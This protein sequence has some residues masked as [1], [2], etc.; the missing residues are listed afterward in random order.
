LPYTR[1]PEFRT[2]KPGTVLYRYM[3]LGKLLHVLQCGCLWFTAMTL[4][5]EHEGRL[6]AADTDE[7][8]F[9]ARYGPDVK[10]LLYVNCWTEG[11]H[12]SHA[13]WALYTG[14]ID[15]VAIRTTVGRFKKALAPAKGEVYLGRVEYVDHD[16][17]TEPILERN[18][19]APWTRKRS[20]LASEREVRALAMRGE[21]APAISLAVDLS[22][23]IEAIVVHPRAQPWFR[24]A[25]E[26]L[27]RRHAIA[28]PVVP[29]R[30]DD[31]PP[32]QRVVRPLP[33]EPTIVFTEPGNVVVFDPATERARG[34][35]PAPKDPS[36]P[37]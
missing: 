37:P 5:E 9:F 6:G 22:A 33:D 32:P 7:H 35:P 8:E 11:P 3:S 17:L 30:I 16:A 14:S 21:Y 19:L 36:P 26:T 12:E 2:P 31:S 20:V 34:S 24:K 29:S 23:L 10:R 15:G 27:L 28:S 25:I 1:H 18:L 13:M 4:M